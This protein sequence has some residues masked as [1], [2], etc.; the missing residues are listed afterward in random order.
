MDG[1]TDREKKIFFAIF[2]WSPVKWPAMFDVNI[3]SF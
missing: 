2:F 3:Q 1:G